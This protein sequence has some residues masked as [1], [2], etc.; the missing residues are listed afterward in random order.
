[1]KRIL[2]SVGAA[3][4]IGVAA[5]GCNS[6]SDSAGSVSA[7]PASVTSSV[8]S[9]ASPSASSVPAG[10]ATL[11]QQDGALVDTDREAGVV[12]GAGF[13]ITIDPAAQTALFQTIDPGTGDA[14]QNSALFDYANGTFVRHVF[15]SAMGTTY[16]YTSDLTTG[17]LQVIQNSAGDD[18]SEAVKGQGRWESAASG[19]ATQRADIETYFE[20]RYGMTIEEAVTA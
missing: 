1:M 9:A 5:T 18:V 14:F 2:A 4:L 3:V 11:S 20:A 19:S 8:S 7:E 15:V 17:E 10:A 16:V 6:Q 13:D 12:E